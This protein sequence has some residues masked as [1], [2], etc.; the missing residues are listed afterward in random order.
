MECSVTAQSEDKLQNSSAES[1]LGLTD[2]FEKPKK[3]Q[4]QLKADLSP[5]LFL[6]LYKY[7][8]FYFFVS[9]K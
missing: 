3:T 4:K 9:F 5:L 2:D 1:G 6:L 7:C 8:D